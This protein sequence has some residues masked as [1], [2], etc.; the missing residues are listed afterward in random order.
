M[1]VLFLLDSQHLFRFHT[2]ILHQDI[3]C[4]RRV[5]SPPPKIKFPHLQHLYLGHHFAPILVF[6]CVDFR[7]EI[8]SC[9]HVFMVPHG[10]FYV[11]QHH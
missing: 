4:P 5:T 8:Q 1:H 7:H 11:W 2:L 6:V 9:T 10:T 3:L